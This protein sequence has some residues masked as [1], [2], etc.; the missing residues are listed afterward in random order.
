MIMKI[1]KTALFIF[2]LFFSFAAQASIEGK[3]YCK[4]YDPFY[5]I[6]YE[7]P[8]L[9]TKTGETY[10]LQEEFGKDKYSGTGIL[11]KSG[12]LAASF[13]NAKKLADSGIEIYEVNGDGNLDGLWTSQ[14]K[15]QIA[16]ESCKKIN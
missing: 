7:G 14:N 13:I 4:G 16:Q 1:N 3:Y 6:A 15:Q 12:R 5:K 9:I 2:S 10:Q 8:M 11:S